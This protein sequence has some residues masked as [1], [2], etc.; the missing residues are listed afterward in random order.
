MRTESRD[1]RVFFIGAGPGDP[2]LITVKGKRLIEA[3]ELVLYTGS[4]VPKEV[5]AC[6]KASALVADS[7]HM[8]LE[9]THA[10]IMQTLNK[11]GSVA[12]VHTGDPGL[13]GAVRE[14]ARLLEA[15]GVDYEIVPGVTAAF[16]AAAAAKVSFTQPEAVQSLIFTRAAGKTPVPEAESIAS[17]AAHGASMAV[18]LSGGKAESLAESLINGGYPETTTVIV[19][20]KVGAPEERIVHTDISHMAEIIQEYRMQSQTVF[21]VLPGESKDEQRSYLYDA[22]RL[23]SS[24]PS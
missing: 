1:I 7:Q 4:L 23:G 24:S 18:Y 12:R 17:F 22:R 9:E 5:V 3:A 10:L 16:A 21:L 19:A 6:A 14:Q 13:Y 2:E 15:E 8:S 20:H 11:G